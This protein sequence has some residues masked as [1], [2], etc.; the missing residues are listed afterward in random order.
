MTFTFPSWFPPGVYEFRDEPTEGQ[1]G[2][3]AARSNAVTVTPSAASPAA[4]V[5]IPVI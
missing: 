5:R 2:A 1:W 4:A 3:M